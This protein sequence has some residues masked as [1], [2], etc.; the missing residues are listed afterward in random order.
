[1]HRD[2]PDLSRGLV[3]QFRHGELDGA[4]PRG[5]AP[6]PPGRSRARLDEVDSLDGELLGGDSIEKKLA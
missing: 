5:E 4:G 1:M 6:R 3:Q 2:D